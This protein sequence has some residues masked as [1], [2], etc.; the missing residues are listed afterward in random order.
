MPL[1]GNRLWPFWTS[2]NVGIVPM[3]APRALCCQHWPRWRGVAGGIVG[4]IYV[5]HSMFP[6][7]YTGPLNFRVW[8][9]SRFPA[10]SKKWM[11]LILMSFFWKDPTNGAFGRFQ[12]LSFNNGLPNRRKRWEEA[13]CFALSTSMDDVALSAA[14]NACEKGWQ[15]RCQHEDSFPFWAPT[16]IQAIHPW[17][18]LKNT[19]IFS[20]KVLDE[21]C[22]CDFLCIYQ[23][24]VFYSFD[25]CF[26]INY[27]VVTRIEKTHRAWVSWWSKQGYWSIPQNTRSKKC[28]KNASKSFKM[29]CI[30]NHQ[31]FHHQT[32]HILSLTRFARSLHALPFSFCFFC[33]RLPKSYLLVYAPFITFFSTR[34][35]LHLLRSLEHDHVPAHNSAISACEKVQLGCRNTHP[36][37]RIRRF[38]MVLKVCNFLV[39]FSYYVVKKT[40]CWSIPMICERVSVDSD[41]FWFRATL[42]ICSMSSHCN[43]LM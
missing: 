3:D 14:I 7:W 42:Q 32:W 4:Q 18:E 5:V 29:G 19:T 9:L 12:A 11:K 6:V 40:R 16:N 39:F 10:L 34:P 41:M 43:I 36:L 15:W 27:R 13:F 33:G 17:K 25:R 24:C 31:W 20:R 23:E 1:S 8:W 35:A 21:N 38:E 28:P 22:F 30:L 2:R 37:P 26:P